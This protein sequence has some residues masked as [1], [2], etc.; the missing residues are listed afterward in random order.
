[1]TTV[2]YG[3]SNF[4]GYKVYRHTSPSK[5]TGL[6]AFLFVLQIRPTDQ[7]S[8]IL[9]RELDKL[10]LLRTA[11]RIEYKVYT[12]SNDIWDSIGEILKIVVTR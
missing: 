10:N 7:L 2:G 9:V 8:G 3:G 12:T 5:G 4:S 11:D 6:Y 1:M